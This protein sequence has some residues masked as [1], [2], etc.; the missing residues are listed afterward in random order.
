MSLQFTR[1]G[2]LQGA[3]A[4]LGTF[5]LGQTAIAQTWPSQAVKII[6]GFAAGGL[7]DLVSRAY[8]EHLSRRLGQTVIVENKPGGT[9]SVAAQ[10]VRLA[11]ADGYTLMTTISGTMFTNRAIYKTLN[12]DADKDFVLIS[13]LRSPPLPYIAHK[14]TGATDLAGF[15][16]Y[17]RNHDVTV[18]S[19]G[20]GSVG[21]I[22]ITQLNKHFG[23]DIRIVHYRGEAPMWQDLLAGTIH[24]ATGSYAGG[25]AAVL[26]GG[27]GRAIAVSTTKRL[28][29]LPEVA[30]F[31]EQGATAR[32]LTLSGFI[33]LFGPAGFP[34][35][36]VE[37]LSALMVD[38]NASE[39]VTK[40]LDTFGYEEGAVGHD[41]ARRIYAEEGPLQIE[42]VKQLDL[43]P[44]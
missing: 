17:A 38:A 33:G 19:Y 14:S 2:L 4:T 25:G 1:R 10:T 9:G 27:A 30:T 28:S 37:R 20:P 40:L 41:E 43:I 15:V 44:E 39:R 6:C 23:L 34:P 21:H 29:K 22:I 36:I 7:T 5:S 16:A 32:G 26:A 11:P 35:S 8:G 24:A 3:G 18:G 42:L 12:Y 31:H 13:C